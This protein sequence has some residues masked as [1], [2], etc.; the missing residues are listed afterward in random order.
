M[1]GVRGIGS[2]GGEAGSLIS[3]DARGRCLRCDLTQHIGRK[4]EQ[5]AYSVWCGG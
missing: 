3:D 4:V 1:S 5:V 2:F